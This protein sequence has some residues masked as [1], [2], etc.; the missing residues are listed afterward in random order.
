[1]KTLFA[2]LSFLLL[3]QSCY[4][5]SYCIPTDNGIFVKKDGEN[6]FFY[7]ENDRKTEKDKI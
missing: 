5:S 2:Y 4:P 1:M 7:V 6:T 3:T